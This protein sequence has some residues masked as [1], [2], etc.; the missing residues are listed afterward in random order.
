MDDILGLG[1]VGIGNVG[2]TLGLLIKVRKNGGRNIGL[3]VYKVYS[4]FTADDAI[5][6]MNGC[7]HVYY[8]AS[9]NQDVTIVITPSEF[10]F[11]G[12]RTFFF[13]NFSLSMAG[14]WDYAKL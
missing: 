1:G 4:G 8:D 7:E 5:A 3:D 13:R 10:G 9:G 6:G 11:V 12:V 2:P 14:L